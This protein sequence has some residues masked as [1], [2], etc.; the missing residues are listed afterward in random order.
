MIGKYAEIAMSTVSGLA[1]RQ[2]FYISTEIINAMRHLASL[3]S[4]DHDHGTMHQEDM[5]T[6][7][8][9]ADL[10]EIAAQ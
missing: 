2:E 1:D 4:S 7:R 10:D 6:R 3:V 9:G 5:N 8:G